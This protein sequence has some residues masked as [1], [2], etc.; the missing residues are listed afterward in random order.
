MIIIHNYN[1]Y[2]NILYFVVY[3]YSLK[4]CVSVNEILSN[5]VSQLETIGVTLLYFRIGK[6]YICMCEFSRIFLCVFNQKY[7]LLL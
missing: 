4:V 6:T 1:N 5:F 7:V 3:Q 2:I